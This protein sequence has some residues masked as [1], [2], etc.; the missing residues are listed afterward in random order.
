MRRRGGAGCPARRLRS[1]PCRR[2]WRA[3]SAR[4]RVACVRSRRCPARRSG[5]VPPSTPA[6]F[7]ARFIA[8]RTPAPMPCPMNGGVRWA[9]SP[10]RNTRRSRHRSASL[11]AEGVLGH[12]DELQ[13]LDRDVAGPRGDQRVQPGH[14]AEVVRGLAGR[15]PE[16]P[17]I[18]GRADP[19]VG[20]RPGAGR[21]PGARLPIGEVGVGVHV[22]DQPALLELQVAHGGADRGAGQAVGAVAAQ[23]VFG[24]ERVLPAGGPVGQIDAH[25]AGGV[26]GERGDLRVAAKGGRRYRLRL[27]RRIA[28]S[29]GWSNMLASG[30]PCLP[31]SRCRA[32]TRRAPACP[33]RAAAARGAAGRSRRTRR[34]ARAGRATR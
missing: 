21:R 18:A 9:A 5:S 16:L 4:G 24:V 27:S 23:H 20:G 8:S 13:P 28:S 1:S 11:G 10:S 17:A 22:D 32:G 3:G 6:S 33:G 29:A 34:R 2:A 19:H 12:A 30:K 14:V 26:L 7:Q 15:Q 31:R 25:S